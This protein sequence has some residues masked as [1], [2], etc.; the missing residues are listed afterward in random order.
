MRSEPC[1]I[2]TYINELGWI[3]DDHGGA[4]G[5]KEA[6]AALHDKTIVHVRRCRQ[7]DYHRNPYFRH[8]LTKMRNDS[9]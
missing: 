2:V 1:F 7:S 9:V 3:E 8:R 4:V 6:A 5:P